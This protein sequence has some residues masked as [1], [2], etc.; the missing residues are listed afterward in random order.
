[1]ASQG[2]KQGNIV[3]LYLS[4]KSVQNQTIAEF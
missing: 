1:V 2:L 4:G 3:I